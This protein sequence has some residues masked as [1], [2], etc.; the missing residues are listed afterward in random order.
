MFHFE[1]SRYNR[2][3]AMPEW[4]NRQQMLAEASVAVIGAG[5]VKSTLLYALAAAG[6]GHIAIFDGDC[7]EMSNLNRQTLFRTSDVGLPKAYQ[8]RDVL[9]NLNPSVDITG[10][11]YFIDDTNIHSELSSFDFI[12][13]G[14]DSP[15]ARNRVNTF[16]LDRRIPYV[17]SSAQ[18]S[19]GY[20]FSVVP[21][22]KTACFACYF[23][24]DHRRREPTGPVPVNVLSVQLAG[25]LGAAEVLKWLLGYRD[26]MITNRRLCFSSLLLSESFEYISQPR[27]PDCP[28]CSHYY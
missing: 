27:R 3:L 6:V 17:H 1:D 21:E 16:C 26:R 8:A 13:E 9:H 18:F 2:Q 11:H 7:V 14:G 15:H 10:H 4:G 25:T 20:V 12:V 28:V 24:N 5:G 19:Y 22:E 23:P